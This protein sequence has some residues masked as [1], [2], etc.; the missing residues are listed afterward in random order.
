MRPEKWQRNVIFEAVEAGGVDPREC[1][2]VYGDEGGRITHL[3]SA[4]YFALSGDP[5]GYVATTVVGESPARASAPFSWASA[6]DRV[7]RWAEEVKRDVDTPDLWADLEREGEILTG[8]RYV[9][10]ENTS[11]TS[12]EQAAIAEQLR[13]IKELVKTTYALSD[14]QM[15]FLEAK[16]DDIGAAASR[17][18]R[19]DWL[20][21]FYGVMFTVIVTGLLPPEAVQH[22][23]LTAVQALEHLFDSGGELHLLLP[24]S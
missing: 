12:A 13:Q 16:L 20:L 15:L 9:D 23:I 14:A 3:P 22:V 5:G 7:R 17:V 24:P 19:K 1:T 21:L 4:S 6:D 10:V 8:A 18:G 2:F 11:F